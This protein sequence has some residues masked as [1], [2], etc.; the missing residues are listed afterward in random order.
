[1]GR[2]S[3]EARI[4][5]DQLGAT[6][7]GVQQVQHRNGMRLGGIATEQKHDFAVVDIIEAVGHR[8]VAEGAGHAGNGRGMADAGLM[9][10]IVGAPHRHELAMQ[11]SGLVGEF[12]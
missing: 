5:H 8:P 1:M 6:L 3:G 7:L 10:S 4:H 11:V 2:R 12:R 9:V